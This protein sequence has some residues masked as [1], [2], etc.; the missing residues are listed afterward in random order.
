MIGAA[1]SPRM[2]PALSTFNP[3]GTLKVL[4]I[5]GFMMLSPMNPQTT[6]GIAASSSTRILSHSRV[7]PVANSAMKIAAPSEKGMATSTARPVT[8]AVPAISARMP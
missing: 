2:M 5:R 3:T 8:L 7:R 1:I 4:M 6:D